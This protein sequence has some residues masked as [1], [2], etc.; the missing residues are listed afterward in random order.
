MPCATCKHWRPDDPSDSIGECTF[1]PTPEP[2][3]M[4]HRVP[5][6][7]GHYTGV[8]DGVDCDAHTLFHD[9]NRPHPLDR[10]KAV[11]LAVAPG[12]KIP[13][14][15]YTRGDI[16]RALAPITRVTPKFV[17]VDFLNREC[18]IRFNRT[19]LNDREGLVVEFPTWGVD[20]DGTVEYAA[21][22]QVDPAAVEKV[23]RK[24]RRGDSI[25]LRGLSPFSHY[26]KNGYVMKTKRDL[27]YLKLSR[28]VSGWMHRTGP[29][30]GTM[31]EHLWEIDLNAYQEKAPDP[32]GSQ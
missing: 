27:L 24:V 22:V 23:L 7:I 15:T 11:M 14:R 16:S 4:S 17:F 28:R 8:H 2:Y 3:W 13:L 12:D 32:G 30:A 29:M 1:R 26:R 10:A 6:I 9:I 5:R 25:P 20:P 18:R 31:D 19:A 21:R